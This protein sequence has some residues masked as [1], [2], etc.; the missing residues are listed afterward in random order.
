MK[1]ELLTLCDFA[2][3][4]PNGKLYVI[5]IFDHIYAPEVPAPA[6]LCA[7]AAR[8][9]FDAIERSNKNV[10]ISFV[11]SDGARVMPD[12]NVQLNIEVP[13]GESSATANVVVMLEQLNLPRYCEYAID[14]AVDGRT[15][16][17]I[18]L[19]VQR[20]VQLRSTGEPYSA[21]S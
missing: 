19:Y 3:G 4:E 2:K 16:G 20:P 14:L 9:R 12:M 13:P 6:P 21:P 18:P 8:L 17:S 10:T 11:D 7:I 5:G 15:E 1:L